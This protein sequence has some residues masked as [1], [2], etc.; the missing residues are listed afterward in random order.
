MSSFSETLLGEEIKI[1]TLV[2]GDGN[3][4]DRSAG[5]LR[6]G[7]WASSPP[8]KLRASAARRALAASYSS[9]SVQCS[10]PY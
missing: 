5:S 2:K 8:F 6:G 1:N 7:L 10:E 3:H 4:P 9:F